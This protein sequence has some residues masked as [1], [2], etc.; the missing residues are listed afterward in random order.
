MIDKIKHIFIE[1]TSGDLQVIQ[2][3]LETAVSE[4]MCSTTVDKVFRAMHTIKGS[5]PMFGFSHLPEIT[6]PVEMAYRNLSDGNLELSNQI[7]D[8]TKD[9]VSL[10]QDVLDMDDDHLPRIE[11]EKQMLIRY[12]NNIN[13]LNDRTND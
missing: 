8:K 10:I 7:I 9:V 2:R 6:L 11:E 13:R 3:E 4:S 12:F 5:G 1:E